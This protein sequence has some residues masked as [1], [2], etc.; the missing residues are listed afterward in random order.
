MQSIHKLP[1]LVLLRPR[2]FKWIRKILNL[3]NRN[4]YIKDCLIKNTN[5]HCSC[6]MQLN[7][8]KN[9]TNKSLAWSIIMSG[10]ILRS[11]SKIKKHQL[12]YEYIPDEIISSATRKEAL[13]KDMKAFRDTVE[14]FR[15]QNNTNS[16]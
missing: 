9:H 4:R 10:E 16:Y 15:S 1:K 3:A 7:N 5:G 2:E 12:G 11:E 6:V 13:K 8:Y 14:S